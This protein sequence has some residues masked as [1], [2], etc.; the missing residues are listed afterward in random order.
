MNADPL[1]VCGPGS[2]IY[3]VH[4]KYADR[5]GAAGIDHALEARNSERSRT[6]SRWATATARPGGVGFCTAL[7]LAGCDDAVHR[8]RVLR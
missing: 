7:K 1:A 5:A 3:Y 8:A 6:T 2:A 4:A